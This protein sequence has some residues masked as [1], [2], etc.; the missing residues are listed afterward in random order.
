MCQQRKEQAVLYTQTLSH[1]HFTAAAA[2]LAAESRVD[3]FPSHLLLARTSR[4]T[5]QLHVMIAGVGRGSLILMN[6]H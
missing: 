6:T 2:T 5:L 3:R 4:E 1:T